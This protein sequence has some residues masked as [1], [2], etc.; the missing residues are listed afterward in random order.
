MTVHKSE[1]AASA[2]QCRHPMWR[3]C[4]RRATRSRSST[5]SRRS[6]CATT[7]A[8]VA[9][10][11]PD[12]GALGVRSPITHSH[13]DRRR[14]RLV[15][16]SAPH[17]DARRDG[18]RSRAGRGWRRSPWPTL[19]AAPRT[20]RARCASRRSHCARAATRGHMAADGGARLRRNTRRRR[21]GVL[22]RADAGGTHTPPHRLWVEL[23][24]TDDRRHRRR[25]Q[26]H[27][28]RPGRPHNA[29]TTRRSS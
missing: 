4:E 3:C 6:C 28:Y 23:R 12:P 15:C 14:R 2:G 9:R 5:A 17:R 11:A 29:S 21:R 8:A 27:R 26:R 24:Q 20:S 1:R 7:G 25:R 13:R 19:V 22:S 10:T 16:S 18:R